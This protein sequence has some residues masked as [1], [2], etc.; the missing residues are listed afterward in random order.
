MKDGF[1]EVN[2]MLW[3]AEDVDC[4]AVTFGQLQDLDQALTYAKARRV[5][6][7]AGG[8]CGQWPIRMARFVNKVYT[9]EPESQNF[10]CLH[11]NT[12]NMSNIVATWG[13]LGEDKRYV[14]VIYPEGKRNM[15]AVQ[16]ELGI[17]NIPMYRIDD[18]DLLVCDFIQLDIEG[19]EPLAVAGA[20]ETI[21]RCR[22][23]IMIEDKGL[24]EKYGYPMGWA[25][26]V[27]HREGYKRTKEINRDVIYTFGG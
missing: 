16:V 7:Q 19:A 11:R 3:P 9:F 4:M 27:L 15:G 26:S 25:D 14:D 20:M 24:S 13:A 22:P 21:R 1:K 6:V 5:A 23:T 17:G 18:L 10:F 2:G 12:L 8:N